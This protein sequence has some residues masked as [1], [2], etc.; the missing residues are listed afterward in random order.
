MILKILKNV[1]TD[2]NS[3]ILNS[4][5][6]D[7]PK[8]LE[9][10]YYLI[11]STDYEILSKNAIILTVE[12]VK[13]KPEWLLRNITNVSE[14]KSKNWPLFL[15]SLL[16]YPDDKVLGETINAFNYYAKNSN[17]FDLS[18]EFLEKL[19]NRLD[20]SNWE[21]FKKI[22]KVLG[23]Y[24]MDE[25][26]LNRFSKLLLEKIENSNDDSKLILLRFFK[27]QDISRLNSN[28][29]AQLLNLKNSKNY[30]I[31]RDIEEIESMKIKLRG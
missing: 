13:N 11:Y 31:K 23:N 17:S 5:D 2:P 27:I 9:N 26:M 14:N 3:N 8:V 28:L 22:V 6:I 16:D 15:N 29:V 1:I 12:I 19:V 4:P 30:D 25:K 24:E 20:T 21:N 10:L 7:N 18:A